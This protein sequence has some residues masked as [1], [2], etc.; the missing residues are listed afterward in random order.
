MRLASRLIALGVLWRVLR[1]ALD[2]PL[3]FD[4]ASTAVHFLDRGFR[5]LLAP[6]GF[7]QVAPLGFLWTE[8]AFV[9]ALGSSEWALRLPSLLESLLSLWLFVRLARRLLDE[10]RALLAIA[11]FASSYYL[12]RHGV[13]AKPY[14][15]DVLV[16]LALVSLGHAALERPEDRRLWAALTLACPLGVW[17]SFPACFVAAGV[18][19]VL[20]IEAMRARAPARTAAAMALGLLLAASFAAMYLLVAREQARSVPPWMADYWNDAFP[21]VTRPARL[22]G[23]LLSI[24]SGVMLAYPIGAA[25]GGSTLTLLCVLA[26]VWWMRD[27]RP[28]L[29][30]LLAPL[31]FTFVAAALRLYP[32]GD[33]IRVSLYMAPAFCLLAGAG[34]VTLFERLLPRRVPGALQAAAAGMALL[35]VGGMAVDVARPY[36]AHLDAQTRDLARRLAAGCRPDDVWGVTV[37]GA[38]TRLRFYMARF[39]DSPVRWDTDPEELPPARGTFRLLCRT[40]KWTEL[41]KE[42]LRHQLAALIPRYGS[43]RLDVFPLDERVAV[44]VYTFPGLPHRSAPA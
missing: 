35:I 29:A 22:L 21:P 7:A 18:V 5:G 27:R 42:R 37:G 23:W 19:T 10:R 31:A 24:H 33:A 34:L 14:G 20:A 3:S 9:K 17:F 16:A 39:C 44:H 28:L 12:V 40:D 26:G 1:Y 4:E 41:P 36:K 11:L 43:P 8:L 25:G 15:G 13:E 6:L 32:Y 38:D 2:F 30:M